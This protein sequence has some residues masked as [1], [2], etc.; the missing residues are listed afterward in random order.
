[1]TDGSY[2]F[3]ILSMDRAGNKLSKS[4]SLTVDSVAPAAALAFSSSNISGVSTVGI[5]ASDANLKSAVLSIGHKLVDVTGVK[6]YKLDTADLA[7]GRYKATLTV[8]D[9]A[10]NVG[11]A[12]ADV[13]VAN[14]TPMIGFAAMAG[15]AGGVVAGATIAWFVASRRHR[16]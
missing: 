1:M 8:L 16:A 5:V 4:W 9:K 2:K 15:I 11:M 12:T 7:D 13:V 3:A 6:E 14:V 10:G